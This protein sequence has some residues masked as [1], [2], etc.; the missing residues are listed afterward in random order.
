MAN[1]DAA[2]VTGR[3]GITLWMQLC[4]FEFALRTTETG[5]QTHRQT[6]LEMPVLDAKGVIVVVRWCG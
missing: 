2:Y 6:E 1:E 5:K 4:L 3:R